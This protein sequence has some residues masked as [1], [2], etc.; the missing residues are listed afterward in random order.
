MA[1]TWTQR[2]LALCLLLVQI[3]ALDHPGPC[4][5][6]A[7]LY[8]TVETLG[9]YY[10]DIWVGTPPQRQSVIVDTGSSLLAFPC[11]GCSQCGTHL[12]KPFN[13]SA[14]STAKFVDCRPEY[15][16]SSCGASN[17]CGYYQGYSEGSTL[18]GVYMYDRVF[19][20]DT[21]EPNSD[22]NV[23]FGCHTRE[24]GL[25]V[26]QKADGILGLAYASHGS[27]HFPTI[28]D[29]LTEKRADVNKDVFSLCLSAAGGGLFV[30]GGWNSS[31]H[32]EEPLFTPI[33]RETYY[34]VQ[35]HDMLLGGK[36]IEAGSAIWNT[37]YGTVIDSGTTFAYLPTQAYTRLISAF[38][39]FCSEPG[40]CLHDS[41]RNVRSSKQA[42][43]VMSSGDAN[44]TAARIQTFPVLD[45]IFEGIAVKWRPSEYLYSPNNVGDVFC[46]GIDDNGP[47]GTVLG[48]IFM[49]EFD[50]IFDR[51]NKRIGFARADCLFG[52]GHR[53]YDPSSSSFNGSVSCYPPPCHVTCFVNGTCSH[54]SGS[55]S[56]PTPPIVV[57][58]PSTP[59]DPS[60]DMRVD[61]SS[62]G[63]GAG[64][65]TLVAVLVGVVLVAAAAL[66]AVIRRRRA[67][68]TRYEMVV[69]TDSE[70]STRVPTS[71][72]VAADEETD[73]DRAGI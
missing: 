47:T 67:P 66:V 20:G 65:I 26:S 51:Q 43:Y 24:S 22:V 29:A 54:S 58:D 27:Q 17:T 13:T 14:S 60:P 68:T 36:S 23:T 44:T 9:Y 45:V 5:E 50:I 16:C 46:L 59:M 61:D 2:C 69:N 42:C 11:S 15:R 40:H 52:N 39:R 62:S 56:S 37:H 64:F 25:F 34:V 19:L 38:N 73:S 18:A 4:I 57:H 12:D 55:P 48:G 7:K 63:G 10:T 72:V 33:T 32:L 6:I 1:T 28:I 70:L 71:V 41:R 49:R 21:Y 31:V 30:V 8:G 53:P 35:M 3:T